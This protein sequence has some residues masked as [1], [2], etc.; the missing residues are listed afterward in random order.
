MASACVFAVFAVSCFASVRCYPPSAQYET[1]SRQTSHMYLLLS[2]L[3][4]SISTNDPASFQKTLIW[5]TTYVFRDVS[6]AID[7]QFYVLE[8]MS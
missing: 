2:T 8:W 7:A 5:R 4:P 1:R 6:D 3:Q